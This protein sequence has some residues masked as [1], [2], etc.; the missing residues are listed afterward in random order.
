MTHPPGVELATIGTANVVDPLHDP[1]P[2]CPNCHAM[3][4]RRS[5]ALT[6]AELQAII[7]GRRPVR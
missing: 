6:I 3:V 1:R 5:P 4:H 2:L 7:C